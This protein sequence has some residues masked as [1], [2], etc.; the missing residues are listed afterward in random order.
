[1]QQS[2]SLVEKIISNLIQFIYEFDIYYDL[3]LN[4]EKDNVVLSDE[5]ILNIRFLFNVR[6]TPL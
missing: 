1:M 6:N 3:I 4:L 2:W 5:D